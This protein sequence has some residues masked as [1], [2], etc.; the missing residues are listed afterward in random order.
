ML[1]KEI[2]T[3]LESNPG[4][5]YRNVHVDLRRDQAVVT[6]DVMVVGFDVDTEI[7]G[8]VLVENCRPRMEIGSIAI[9][10]LLTPGFVK[11]QVKEMVMEALDWYPEDYPLCL[12]KILLEEDRA[13]IFGYRR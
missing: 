7:E 4:L 10:G 1:N 12:E 9:A 8:T 2:E 6:G 3:L 5:P 11:E 13:T